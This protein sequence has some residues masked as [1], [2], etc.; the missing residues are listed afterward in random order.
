MTVNFYM[1]FLKL[2]FW[3][4]NCCFI[5][6]MSPRFV[7]YGTVNMPTLVQMIENRRQSMIGN[8]G[9]LVC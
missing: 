9:G 7:P 2:I 5:I 8:S 3:Y 6:Q 1:T 4:E